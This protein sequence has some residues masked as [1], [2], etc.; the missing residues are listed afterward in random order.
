MPGG[1]PHPWGWAAGTARVR[2]VGAFSAGRGSSAPCTGSAHA[3]GRVVCHTCSQRQSWVGMCRGA[4]LAGEDGV[5]CTAVA[6]R[7]PL[8]LLRW[9]MYLVR[10][11]GLGVL[12][13]R[14]GGAVSIVRCWDG[15]WS[16][17]WVWLC[18]S[19][20]VRA[21]VLTGSVSPACVSAPEASSCWGWIRLLAAR[22]W[23]GVP[24]D[25]CA[26]LRG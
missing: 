5:C 13:P 12:P 8:L 15:S 11:K 25:Q 14:S 7:R 19:D 4:R 3:S 26:V 6:A 16:L 9:A 24:L 20:V 1:C 17:C 10:L 22:A 23:S 18:T 2:L 21:G